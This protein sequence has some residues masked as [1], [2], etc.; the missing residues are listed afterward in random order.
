MSDSRDTIVAWAKWAVANHAH[1][2]YTEGPQR[3]EALGTFPIKFPVFADC[4]AA[5]TLWFWL[6]GAADPNGGTAYKS[7]QF[8]REGYTGTLFGHGTKIDPAHVVPGDV[9]IYGANPGERTALVVEVHG[10]DILTV[11]HGEEGDPSLVW[12]NAPKGPNPHKYGHDG[13]TPQTFLRFPVA[14]I[15]TLHTPPVA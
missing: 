12:V 6:S 9:V 10:T 4:S 11:S 15:G 7:N 5:V 8:G 3:M 14:T 2:H 1:F 13:R